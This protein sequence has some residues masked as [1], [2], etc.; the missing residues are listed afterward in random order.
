MYVN[1]CE[2]SQTGCIHSFITYFYG[3]TILLWYYYIHKAITPVH[4]IHSSPNVICHSLANLRVLI[5][6]RLHK[7][8]QL[9]LAAHS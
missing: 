2:V 6:H 7:L 1:P 3:F 8:L 9:M 5:S 4:A